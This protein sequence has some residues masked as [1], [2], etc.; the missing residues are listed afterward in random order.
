MS[1]FEDLQKEIGINII[2]N[3]NGDGYLKSSLEEISHLPKTHY[4][5][6]QEVDRNYEV[7]PTYVLSTL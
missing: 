6:A 7:A 3:L 5:L 2:G 4:S 1:N